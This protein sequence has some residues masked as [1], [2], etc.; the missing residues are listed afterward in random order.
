MKKFGCI[1]L[2]LSMAGAGASAATSTAEQNRLREAATVLTDLRSTPEKGI[3]DQLWNKA[4]CVIV[5]PSVKKAAFIFG[6]EYGKGVASCRTA[7]GWSAP[8][9]MELE[10][11]SWGAQIGAEQ[12]DLVLLVMNRTG[13]DKLLDNKVSL[14]AGASVAAGP[15]GR[16]AG[17]STDGKLSAEILSYSRSQGVFAGI[18]LA[19]G[20]L[21]PD[22][23]ANADVYG[24]AAT[25]HQVV[26][27]KSITAPADTQ[28]FL[29]AL[30]APASV[31]APAATTGRD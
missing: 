21:G 28:V 26:M 31:P 4:A 5:I 29:T 23:D 8:A 6:G 19:G 27:D 16:A 15:V 18:D 14:G 13:M 25:A 22:K 20:K 3:P 7:N 10:K 24:P 12:I 9:F 1:V 17:A 11:G 30:G 2:L